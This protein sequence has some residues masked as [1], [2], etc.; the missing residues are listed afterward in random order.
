MQ[1]DDLAARVRGLAT[2]LLDDDDYRELAR[3]RDLPE[4]A[5][6]LAGH[7]LA[8]EPVSGPVAAAN[9]EIQV[10]RAAAAQLQV[11]NRWCGPRAAVLAV[12]FED[13]DR[14]SLRALVRGAAAGAAPAA[15]LAGLIPTSLLP[16][17]ALEELAGLTSPGEIGALL[18]TWGN[19]YASAI[20]ES[21][22]GAHPDLFAME[23]ALSRRFAGRAVRGAR[24][25]DAVLR[26][27][28][29]TTIDLENVFTLLA[30]HS[31]EPERRPEDCF[32]PGGRAIPLELFVHASGLESLAV[33][34][35]ELAARLAPEQMAEPILERHEDPAELE[36]LLLRHRIRRLRRRA[37]LDPLSTAPV[38][39]FALELRHEVRRLQR[40]IWGIGLHAPVAVLAGPEAP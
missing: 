15:R 19:P 29:A 18:A 38:L 25:G 8:I 31:A 6:R 3:A 4:L 12:I 34:V 26:H 23:V 11:L 2:H 33:A 24:K 7:G 40:L 21:S 36:D 9:L 27:Y 20:L 1:I 16:A 17:R 28:V 22:A 30:M 14:R 13:E 35:G 10:R 32:I 5:A 39:A 37:R